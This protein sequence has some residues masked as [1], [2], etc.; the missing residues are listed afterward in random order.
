MVRQAI[1]ASVESYSIKE[2][3]VFYGFERPI[4][5]RAASAALRHIE[6]ALELDQEPELGDEEF[7]VVVGYNKDDCVSTLR[8][9]DWL[10]TLRAERLAAGEE[11]LRPVAARADPSEKID[12]RQQ[13][14]NALKQRL[15][16]DIPAYATDRNYEDFVAP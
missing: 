1:R 9:R 16:E 14:V 3:E 15:L 2:L 8:L 5:L 4:D 6:N 7:A 13:R 12:E 11:I 10:E